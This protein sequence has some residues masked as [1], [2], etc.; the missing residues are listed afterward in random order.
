MQTLDFRKHLEAVIDLADDTEV[1]FVL[2]QA[3]QP[4]ADD[5]VIVSQQKRDHRGVPSGLMFLHAAACGLC[6]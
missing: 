1:R 3:P 4:E 2:H 5:G 6:G